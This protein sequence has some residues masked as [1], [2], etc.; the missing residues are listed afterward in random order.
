MHIG[1]DYEQIDK[2]FVAYRPFIYDFLVKKHTPAQLANNTDYQPFIKEYFPNGD[3]LAYGTQHYSYV[4]ELSDIHLSSAW[5]KVNCSV[6]AIHGE[7]DLEAIDELW[8][9][10]VAEIVNHYHPEKGS[11]E[12]LKGTEHGYTLVPSMKDNVQ[13]RMDGSFD[14]NSLAENFNQE[15]VKVVTKWLENQQ[16]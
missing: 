12:V 1:V 6:L 15:L 7:Y 11:Y 9:K 3:E 2:N 13:M 16:E 4:Q 14:W 8:A 10:R 5:K